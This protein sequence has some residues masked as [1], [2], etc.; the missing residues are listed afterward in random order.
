MSNLIMKTNYENK[1]SGGVITFKNICFKQLIMSNNF[2]IV[3][4]KMS[5]ILLI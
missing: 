2:A 4:K 3:I 1:I 5:N